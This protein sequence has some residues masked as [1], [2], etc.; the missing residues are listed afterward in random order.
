[1]MKIKYIFILLLALPSLF[2]CHKEEVEDLFDE[3]P[4]QRTNK[5][6]S[7]I[8]DGLMT[9]EH[10]WVAD[11]YFNDSTMH[12]TMLFRFDED[13][14]VEIESVYEDY[15]KRESNY[16]IRYSQ[17]I[18]LIFDTYS[19]MSLLV[20]AVKKADFR[21]ELEQNS[22]D[23]YRFV[24]RATDAE[25]ATV[26]VLNRA[27]ETALAYMEE[28]F[29]INK[30]RIKITRDPSKSFFRNLAFTTSPLKLSFEFNAGLDVATLSGLVN[31]EPITHTTKV[32]VSKTGFKLEKPLILDGMT[33]SEFTY[34][35]AMD[36]FLISNEGGPEGAIMYDNAPAFTIPGIADYF[37]SNNFSIVTDYSNKLLPHIDAIKTDI[38]NF[39]AFQL[40]A[41]WGYLLCL[42]DPPHDGKNN[43]SGFANVG[44]YKA[45][46]DR[47]LLDPSNMALFKE[48]FYEVYKTNTSAQLFI[49][50]LLDPNGLYVV[51]DSGNDFFLISSS[52]P[53][54]YVKVT[55]MD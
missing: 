13:N 29:E 15:R 44:Y 17:Q 33:I 49:N 6:V 3:S 14:R 9:S 50:I 12:T 20:D 5:E 18:D 8:R 47:I 4:E 52:Y 2:S 40:Y 25:G 45:D 53:D 1:M 19:V 41:S 46:E 30:M 27:D 7:A 48:W 42:T 26:L 37:L 28:L 16:S 31:E 35:E 22:E 38:P 23:S 24:S 34:S 43:W 11:Y 51:Y 32:I 54:Y 21:W 55:L 10:G 36:L 39:R